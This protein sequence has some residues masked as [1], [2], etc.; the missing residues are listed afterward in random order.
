MSTRL[1]SS[2]FVSEVQSLVNWT[3]PT[4]DNSSIDTGLVA[5]NKMKVMLDEAVAAGSLVTNGIVSTYSLVYTTSSAYVG[6]VLAPN[7][8]INFIPYG[9]NRGQRIN[10]VGTVST[11]SL[12]YST[13]SAA[14]AG[15][16]LAPNGDVNFIP[17]SAAVGQKL[18]SSGVVSTYSL[19]Y[20]TSGAY[21]G[22]VLSTSGETH[23]I[24]YNANRGQKISIAGVVSTYSL[25]YTT[26]GAYSGGVLAPNG[27]I[28]F[29]P[30]SATVGQKISS[31]GV[32]STYSIPYPVAVASSLLSRSSTAGTWTGAGTSA[33]PYA[34]ASDIIPG[35]SSASV[36]GTT[37]YLFPFSFTL[38]GA[39]TIRFA[40][41]GRSDTFNDVTVLVAVFK[42]GTFM[43]NTANTW[44]GIYADTS[45]RS[46][47]VGFSTPYAQF[48]GTTGDIFT[49][50]GMTNDGNHMRNISVYAV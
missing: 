46:L 23:F 20:T 2:K 24:P 27:D 1:N 41:E 5:W 38:N 42:N 25:V 28:N 30:F 39:G 43:G 11:Y 19:V 10:S 40:Y 36:L 26:S 32:V 31:T 29:I 34:T 12:V 50:Y 15:G 13:V 35:A 45:W 49:F 4:A 22:G 21:L 8:D 17:Y 48:S 6:G 3:V 47:N 7:G 14:Y 9:A 44:F 18:N 16:V 33:S 37:H